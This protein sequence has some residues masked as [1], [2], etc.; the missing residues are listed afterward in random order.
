MGKDHSKLSRYCILTIQNTTGKLMERV[1]ARKLAR[2][3]GRRSALH[4]NQ[5]WYR[6]RKTLWKR[7]QIRIRCLR[8]FPEEGTNSGRGGRSV[9]CVQQGAIQT[10]G[11]TPCPIWRQLD[12]HIRLAAALQERKVAMRLRDWTTTP[13]QLTMGFPQ[14]S[15]CSQ[16]SAMSTQRDW[17]I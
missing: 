16:S 4:Q 8:I 6:A 3:L 14:G 10:A 2:D 17:R 12:A 7:S 9:R 1:V 13:Q 11:G 5:G 15:P